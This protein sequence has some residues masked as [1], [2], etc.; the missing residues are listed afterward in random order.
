M[1]KVKI[2]VNIGSWGPPQEAAEQYAEMVAKAVDYKK[3]E[4]IAKKNQ[5]EL[6]EIKKI[7]F[8]KIQESLT[9]LSELKATLEQTGTDLST[10]KRNI[11]SLQ[12]EDTNFLGYLEGVYETESEMIEDIASNKERLENIETDLSNQ[13]Q[14]VEALEVETEAILNAIALLEADAE[15][16][17][18]QIKS[19]VDRVQLNSASIGAITEW[20]GIVYNSYRTL[21][22]GI[23][24]II[25]SKTD[26]SLRSDSKFPVAN[27]TVKAKF[28]EL[29]LEKSANEKR[30]K[31]IEL[32]INEDGFG[33]E[34]GSDRNCRFYQ[35]TGM[36]GKE[37][38]E[39]TRIETIEF[40]VD[41]KWIDIHSMNELDYTSYSLNLNKVIPWDEMGANLFCVWY[42]T[43]KLGQ[44]IS[45]YSVDK[46][47]LTYVMPKYVFYADGKLFH[48]EH[49]NLNGVGHLPPTEPQKDGYTFAGWSVEGSTDIEEFPQTYV[50]EDKTFVA[51]FI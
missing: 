38:P 27:K 4:E 6:D 50:T 34:T 8:E 24:G 37:I 29:E 32:S 35:W 7:D 13:M 14:T 45:S 15:D 3:T 18:S 1:I 23:E 9:Q 10:I 48:V 33:I 5:T 26:L 36:G 39:G 17:D 19:L 21:Y 2:K 44:L 12:T 46:I 28:D 11:Y 31:T 42:P 49:C 20:Y 30:T 51:N 47:R 41:G 25:K 22:D 40:L 43:N 16:S